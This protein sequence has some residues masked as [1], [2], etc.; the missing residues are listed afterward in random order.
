[1][2]WINRLIR[3]YND[4]PK[5]YWFK[6]KIFG[7]DWIPVTW[8]GWL[9]LGL[10][11][12]GCIFFTLTI[13][14]SSSTREMIFT[15]ILPVTLLTVTLIRIAYK[16]GEKSRWQWGLPDDEESDT[17]TSGDQEN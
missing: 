11:V 6:R 2:K 1:M 4:N 8:Q 3:Y 7:W 17:A 13:D 12:V 10:Y 15:F 16:K 14:E 5:G 9:V